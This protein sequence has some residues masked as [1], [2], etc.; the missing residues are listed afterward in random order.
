[1]GRVER[2]S[3]GKN[4]RMK[5]KTYEY[6]I[7]TVISENDKS[8][9]YLASTSISDEPVVVKVL[10]NGDVGLV[11]KIADINSPFLP[12]IYHV[13]E[14]G[15]E[16]A[17]ERTLT[18]F[19]EYIGGV[20]LDKYISD[21]K[22][23]ET[24]IVE[25]LLQICAGIRTLHKQEPSIIHR[26]LKPANILVQVADGLPLIKII[27]FDASR[28]FKPDKPYDTRALGTDTYAPPEQFGYSQTDV[29]SDIYSLG[30]VMD[31]ITKEIDVSDGF[32]AVIAKATMFDPDHRYQSIDEFTKALCSYGHKKARRLPILAAVISVCV[33]ALVAGFVLYIG[34]AGENSISKNAMNEE[35]P[36]QKLDTMDPETGASVDW[37]FYYLTE[38]PE[39]SPLALRP[40]GEHGE[41]VDIRILSDFD[42]N[43]KEIDS[44][45]WSED[46]DG[47]VCIEN[48]FLSSLDKNIKYTVS[49]NFVDIRLEFNLMCIDDKKM[50]K[51]STPVL[52]PGYAEFIKKSPGNIVLQTANTFG[53]NLTELKNMDSGKV[54]NSNDFSYDEKTGRVTISKEYL[55]KYNDGDYV[56]LAYTFGEKDVEHKE[57][58]IPTVTICVRDE[59]YIMPVIKQKGVVTNESEDKD[60]MVNIEYNSAKGKLEDVFLTDKSRPDDKPATLSPDDYVVNDVGISIRGTYL[61][62]LK[63]GEYELNF[64]FGDVARSVQLTVA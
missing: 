58:D 38:T 19:E 5:E 35:I 22:L 30:S 32:R 62:T 45:Y 48:E 13:G 29:R 9:V 2:F 54:L 59:P 12:K 11:R 46:D 33:L 10:K 28:E 6:D 55:E 60:V 8:K 44:D 53:E 50:A 4:N 56:N 34:N 39:L 15:G 1:M 51:I 3:K 41:V 27:D 26:D 49:V 63:K 18:I 23:N 14:S 17:K 25:L 43:G 57:E 47:F 42:R 64:E 36:I 21:N 31:E 16:D 61:K 37:V 20:T 7:I 52:N 24:Q 40:M